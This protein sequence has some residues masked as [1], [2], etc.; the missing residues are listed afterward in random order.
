LKTFAGAVKNLST[1]K[2]LGLSKTDVQLSLETFSLAANNLSFGVVKK[3][4][5][6]SETAIQL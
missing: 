3:A 2:A 1:V 6:L 5:Q 4:I